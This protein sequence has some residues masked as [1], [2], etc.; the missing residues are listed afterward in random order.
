MQPLIAI[1]VGEVINFDTGQAWTPTIYGQ[2][3]TYTDAVVRAGGAPLM[4]P[5]VDDETALRRLY[6]QCSGLLLSGGHDLK[7]VSGDN[8]PPRVKMTASPR[9][10]KQ[11]TQLLKWALEDDKPVL[12]ICR[13]MQ[14]LNLVLGGS[15]HHD[16]E[17]DLPTAANHMLNIDKKD[18]HHLAHR[19]TVAPDSQLA[20]ILGK[21]RIPTNSL[22]HQAIRELG[23]GLVATAHAEDGVIEAIELPGKRFVI[24]VQSHPEVLEAGTEPLWGKLF[25]AFVDAA[26]MA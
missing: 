2:F 8:P 23:D 4:L 7:A 22:H 1:T 19:I 12:G 14:L 6:D 16:I 20:A 21:R 9:R 10:D 13:G 26:A 24:G 18:F 11:E 17:N 15:L 25:Q 3:R 5:L